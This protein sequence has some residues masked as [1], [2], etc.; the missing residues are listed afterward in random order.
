MGLGIGRTNLSV[1]EHEMAAGKA[2]LIRRLFQNGGIYPS[3]LRRL[4]QLASGAHGFDERRRIFL[5]DRFGALHFLKPVLEGDADA[6]FTNGDDEILQRLWAREN[7]MPGKPSLESILLAPIESHRTECFYN[8]DP[9][10]YP[11]SFVAKLPG[12]VKKTLCWRAAPSGNAN[13]TGY[14]A[15][16]GNFS[17]ILDSLRS[18][19]CPV[20][21]F[22]PAL[23]PSMAVKCV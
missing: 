22:F 23:D 7:G 5:A 4:N 16:I 17:S 3:Y 8:L 10:R 18:T 19:G 15:V 11:S 6:F 13:L 9:V 2:R 1:F 12:C 21:L 20:E 14:G